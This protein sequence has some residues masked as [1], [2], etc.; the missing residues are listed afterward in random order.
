MW[1]HQFVNLTLGY[2]KLYFTNFWSLLVSNGSYTEN[3][4]ELQNRMN[5]KNYKLLF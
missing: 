1:K 2:K 4:I 3:N 5:E